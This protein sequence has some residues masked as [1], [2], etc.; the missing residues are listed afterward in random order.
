MIASY[1]LEESASQ[2]KR[3]FVMIEKRAAYFFARGM[4]AEPNGCTLQVSEFT[5]PDVSAEGIIV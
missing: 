3:V 5:I 2:A 1:N 4:L